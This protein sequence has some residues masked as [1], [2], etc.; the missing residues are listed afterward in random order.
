MHS[1]R[2]GFNAT[3]MTIFGTAGISKALQVIAPDCFII[4][5]RLNAKMSYVPDETSGI[6]W[7]II[8][9]L[10]QMATASFFLPF[11]SARCARIFLRR[12][13]SFGPGG[14]PTG[15]SK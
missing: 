14:N 5:S 15:G 3:S 1:D 13:Q 6:I 12:N 7:C 9:D 8:A 2:F 11:F 4:L 10:S